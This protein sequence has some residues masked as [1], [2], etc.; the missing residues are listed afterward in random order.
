MNQQRK[1]ARSFLDSSKRRIAAI[2]EKP[3][4]EGSI[5]VIAYSLKGL[6]I[7][8]GALV[9]AYIPPVL[10]LLGLWYDANAPTIVEGVLIAV[11]IIAG[12]MLGLLAGL[13]MLVHATLKS[14][15]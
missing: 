5:Q 1:Q 11:L 10:N 2:A 13:G 12:S 7:G 9:F 14:R 6:G 3:E 8:I 4:L 15:S